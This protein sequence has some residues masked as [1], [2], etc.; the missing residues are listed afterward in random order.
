MKKVFFIVALLSAVSSFGQ[1]RMRSLEITP[2]S[3]WFDFWVGEWNIH[4]FGKDSVK[5][6]GTNKISRIMNDKVLQEDF[7]ILTG[8]NKGFA[9][10]SWSVYVPQKNKWKQTWVDNAGNYMDFIGS[11]EGENRVFSREFL[12]GDSA[13]VIQKMVFSQVTPMNF[14]WD[15]LSSTD[16]GKTW[17]N[18]WQLF[19]T[20]KQ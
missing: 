6:T 3:A 8:A 10:M 17:T 12:R 15:W 13:R 2:D 14:V 4:W 9:G 16:G 1:G 11:R 5:E 7:K 19:Y 18:L 20:R